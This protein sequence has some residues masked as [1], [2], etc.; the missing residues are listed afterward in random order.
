MLLI[1]VAWAP[2]A[3]SRTMHEESIAQKYEQWMAQ[4]GRTYEDQAEKDM[5]L[6]IFKKNSEFIE[7]FN[8]VANRT[9]KLSINE[10][11]DLTNEEFVASHTG[12]KMLKG[13]P[14]PST[15]SFKYENVTEVPSSMDWRDKEAVTQVKNQ[16]KC[17][18]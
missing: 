6:Q 10:F 13:Q 15:K 7:K 18:Q 2:H 11:A 17:G 3:M 5:R 16:G 8:N 14:Q 1:L 4:Y 12:Y 9:Y